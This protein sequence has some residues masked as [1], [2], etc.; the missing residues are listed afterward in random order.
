[1]SLDSL[2]Y[3][4]DVARYEFFKCSST[5]HINLSHVDVYRFKT[6]EGSQCCPG[7]SQGLMHDAL[8]WQSNLGLDN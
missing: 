8:Q 4:L 2:L 5:P 6:V 3:S 1:M 7:Y